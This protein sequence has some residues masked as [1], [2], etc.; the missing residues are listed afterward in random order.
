[1]ILRVTLLLV[2][3]LAVGCTQSRRQTL[4][5]EH[6]ACSAP[7]RDLR[8]PIACDSLGFEQYA[9]CCVADSS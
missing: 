6:C 8:H 3:V 4:M 9:H 2:S 7:D 1:V 5:C